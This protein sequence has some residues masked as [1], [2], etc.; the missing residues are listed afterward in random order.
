M[1]QSAGEENALCISSEEL[2]LL[3]EALCFLDNGPTQSTQASPR[4]QAAFLEL[5]QEFIGASSQIFKLT[6]TLSQYLARTETRKKTN[7]GNAPSLEHFRPGTSDHGLSGQKQ[8]LW[9]HFNL[10]PTGATRG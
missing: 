3:H 4:C 5:I 2:L 7:M 1:F 10:S 9:S 8:A 6:S